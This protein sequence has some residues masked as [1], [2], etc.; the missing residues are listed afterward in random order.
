MEALVSSFIVLAM[1]PIIPFG[2]V[3][4]IHFQ[5]RRDKKAALKL[6]MDVTT[7]FLIFSVSALFNNVFHS[8]FG[9][10]LILIIL[11]VVG[12]LIGGAQT[13]LKGK[14]DGRKLFRVVW[15]LAFA[16]T[17]VAYVLLF[18]ISF[19]TYITAA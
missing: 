7:L 2:L 6:A 4:F 8:T 11:L 9:F 15:R 5:V 1:I 19:I 10:Y 17:G 18:L 3:Y 12:G 13:R 16:G 14:V